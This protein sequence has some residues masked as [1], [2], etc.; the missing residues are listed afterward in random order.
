MPAILF[1]RKLTSFRYGKI[2]LGY[3]R[4]LFP[5]SAKVRIRCILEGSEPPGSRQEVNGEGKMAN[6]KLQLQVRG[7]IFLTF[8]CRPAPDNLLIP[9][10]PSAARWWKYPATIPQSWPPALPMLRFHTHGS[11]KLDGL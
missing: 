6:G 4:K 2:K 5:Y 3:Y 1:A 9:G 8:G 10:V 11:D 7:H